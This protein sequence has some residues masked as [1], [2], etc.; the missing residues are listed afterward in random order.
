MPKKTIQTDRQTDNDIT[1]V[2]C[3]FETRSV[4][5]GFS[6]YFHTFSIKY[7]TA[8]FKIYFLPCQTNMTIETLHSF[9][10]AT[11]SAVWKWNVNLWVRVNIRLIDKRLKQKTNRK[12]INSECDENS[13]ENDR[14][15]NDPSSEESSLFN[16]IGHSKWN[17]VKWA[18]IF[19]LLLKRIILNIQIRMN[20]CHEYWQKLFHTCP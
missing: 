11:H 16:W 18:R 3:Y 14:L 8:Q 10:H 7:Q 4:T 20:V 19:H 12:V 5:S 9:N 15:G 6:Q 13:V 17:M 2:Y 1:D